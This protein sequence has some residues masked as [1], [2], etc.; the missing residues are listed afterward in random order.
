M[1]PG[2][3]ASA[4][5]PGSGGADG[6]CTAAGTCAAAGQEPLLQRKS[7]LAMGSRS[8]DSCCAFATLAIDEGGYR[9]ASALWQVLPIARALQR[10][11]S[12]FPLLLL[13]NV[14]RFPD[15][16]SVNATLPALGVQVL[17]A[18]AVP[19]PEQVGQTFK[20]GYWRQAWAKL[21]IWRLTQYERILWMD[22]DAILTRNMDFVFDRQGMWMMRDTWMCRMDTAKPCSGLM[23]LQPSEDTYQ[24]LLKYAGT[25]QKLSM[26]D[27]ELIVRYFRSVAKTQLRTFEHLEASFGHCLGM[28]PGINS[29][30]ISAKWG[31]ESPWRLPAF[32]HKSS[33]GNECFSFDVARQVRWVDGSR[34]NICHYHPLGAYWRDAFCSATRALKVSTDSVAKFCDDAEWYAP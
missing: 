23:L 7:S 18:D 31:F 10:F 13:T 4:A 11:Q 3:V 22:S 26:A 8:A 5:E 27:Q 32:V 28:V 29:S 16:Q 15:G 33:T 34:M 14:E 17:R 19:I 30:E 12:R 24:G 1:S 20:Y 21:Q 2:A 6:D 9:G 25:L